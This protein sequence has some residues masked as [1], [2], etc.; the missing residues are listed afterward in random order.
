MRASQICWRPIQA[1]EPIEHT[2]RFL[3]HRFGQSLSIYLSLSLSLYLSL[4]LSS[5]F[6]TQKKRNSRAVPCISH[7]SPIF[8]CPTRLSRHVPGASFQGDHL[9]LVAL[10]ASLRRE[11]Q[12]DSR[13]DCG[14]KI[15]TPN[16]TLISG[17]MDQNLRSPGGL[18]LTH[19][20]MAPRFLFLVVLQYTF[21]R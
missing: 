11:S 15:G 4:S 21:F 17:N 18:I 20:Q 14:S 3:R 1:E 9:G 5:E 12:S 19:P 16:G 7:N 2:R 6:P 10:R 13:N 8:T